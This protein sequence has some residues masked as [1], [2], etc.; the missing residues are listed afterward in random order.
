MS[1][2]ETVRIMLLQMPNS[3]K[4][5]F[6]ALY[7]LFCSGSYLYSWQEGAINISSIF[8]INSNYEKD[9][10]NFKSNNEHR[11]QS[12]TLGNASTEIIERAK[13]NYKEGMYNILN[14]EERLNDSS[15][16]DDMNFFA[17]SPDSCIFNVPEDIQQDW[18]D[19]AFLIYISLDMNYD[20]LSSHNKDMFQKLDNERT[21]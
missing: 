5:R 14:I 16:P 7:H 17:I 9:L 6:D 21:W 13:R 20:I 1:E 2:L 18:L 12:F 8:D 19:A 4:N 3:Y 11:I 10:Y 15:I